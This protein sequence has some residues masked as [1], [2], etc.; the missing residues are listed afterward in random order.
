MRPFKGY[1]RGKSPKYGLI[2]LPTDHGVSR[3]IELP[4]NSRKHYIMFLEDLIMRYIGVLFPGYVIHSWHS[5]KVTRD[6]DLEYEDYAEDDLIE[7]VES[8]STKRAIGLPNR[9]QYD[10]EMPANMLN[11]LLE[12]FEIEHDIVVKGGKTNNFRDFFSFPNPKSPML[13]RKKHIP[14]RYTPLENSVSIFEA[15]ENDNYMLHFPYHTFDYFIQFLTEAAHDDTVTEIKTTQY[16]VASNSGVVDALID[17]AL[18]GKK[19]TVLVELKAR[20]DEEVNLQY[21]REMKKAGINILYSIQGFK[22]HSKVALIQRVQDGK[23]LK[24]LA[25]IGTGNFN[26]KTAKI[27]CDHGYFTSH[28]GITKD[29]E[30]LFILLERRD[31]NIQFNHILVPRFN[32][33]EQYKAHI[34]KE[35]ENVKAGK[36]GYFLLKMNG[37][38]DPAMIEYLYKASEAGVKIDCLIRGVCC[39]VP[40][41][42]YSKN[43]RV[44]RIVDRFLEHARVFVFYDNGKNHIYAGSADWMKRNLYRRI[45]CVF[46]I[47]DEDIKQ[48]I[49]DILNIQLSDNVNGRQ[50]NENLEN[51]PIH[52]GNKW[53]RAQEEIYYYLREKQKGV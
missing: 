51:E 35:I 27:Y 24:R 4:G 25:F 37:L 13:E 2:K 17:A 14:L 52:T 15:V 44:I 22:V 36:E 12:T 16:R 49:L 33:V 38:E 1:K 8:L 31:T 53:I 50:L 19:V 23:T 39:L 34:D 11:F 28:E 43:I 47:Y 10:R 30:L 6:A 46:P 40:N 3:F 48:E 18:N 41:Q 9:F 42:P 26:E 45:E 20:F 5:I 29:L 32:M 21:A 7:V